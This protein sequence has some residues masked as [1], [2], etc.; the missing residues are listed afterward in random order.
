MTQRGN[1]VGLVALPF[2]TTTDFQKGTKAA[3]NAIIADLTSIDTFDLSF[4]WDPF[5]TV[6]NR[7][8]RPYEE[9]LDDPYLEKAY[10]ERAVCD[11]LDDGGFPLSLGGEHTVSLGPI[12]AVRTRGHL[13]VVQIDAQ[14]N[15]K[16]HVDGQYYHHETVMRRILEMGCPIVGVGI[17]SV[18]EE[19]AAFI[20]DNGIPIIDG[21]RTAKTKNWYSIVDPLP[22]RVYLTIDLSGIN[23]K[24]APAVAHPIPGG[25]NYPKLLD[26][27]AYLF[28]T[29]NVVGADIV[30]LTP[31]DRDKTTLR[32]TSRLIT[33]L[34]ALKYPSF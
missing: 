10:A 32:L 23:P 25:P 8:Y 12:R 27:I 20:K 31:G 13:G 4:G 5:T 33:A 30:E 9:H 26:F 7:F 24:A 22:D 28:K 16:D 3:P 18:S 14:A 15:L 2:E 1:F 11:I 21:K 29:K 17:R 6:A 19:E 34:V